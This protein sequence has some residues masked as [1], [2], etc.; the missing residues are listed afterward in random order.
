MDIAA[1]T[2]GEIVKLM[3]DRGYVE[4]YQEAYEML[5]FHI[6]SKEESTCM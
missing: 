2:V 5:K 3:I 6:N 1:W 4:T